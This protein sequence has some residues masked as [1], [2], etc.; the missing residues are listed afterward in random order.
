MPLR[1]YSYRNGMGTSE[2]LYKNEKVS[3]KKQEMRDLISAAYQHVTAQ[4]WAN[5]LDHTKKIES[6]LWKADKIQ[7]DKEPFLIHLSSSSS[8]SSYSPSSFHASPTGSDSTKP[9]P[10]R[11]TEEFREGITPLPED[12]GQA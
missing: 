11:D 7:D 5:Y 6:D 4:N 1:T 8:S 2:E 3:F 10:S 9:G 12:C